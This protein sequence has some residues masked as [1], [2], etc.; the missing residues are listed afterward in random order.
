MDKRKK[1]LLTADNIKKDLKFH[2]LRQLFELI[3]SAIF[4]VFGFYLFKLI[5]LFI[6]G[7]DEIITI[8]IL[9]LYV[10]FFSSLI[11][12]AIVN[13]IKSLYLSSKN[14]YE[15]ITDW[16]VNKLPKQWFPNGTLN[17]FFYRPYTLVFA[18]NGKYRIPSYINYKWSD[19][20]SMQDIN[21]YEGTSLNDEFYIVCIGK[22]K[23]IIA[24]NTNLFELLK[25]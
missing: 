18:K 16:V 11:I 6:F 9:F 23:N 1:E 22:K 24:Y 8:I 21:V 3:F 13:I 4:V 20:F 10:L 25:K 17:A 15:I 19:W 12:Y 14:K 2:F 5:F 7:S